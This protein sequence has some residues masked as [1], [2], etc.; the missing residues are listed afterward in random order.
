MSLGPGMRGRFSIRFRLTRACYQLIQPKWRS[1]L[2]KIVSQ[3][4]KRDSPVKWFRKS[5]IWIRD[6]FFHKISGRHR[7]ISRDNIM[8]NTTNR[9]NMY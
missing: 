5:W 7:N 6:I 8:E 2:D 9:Y 1:L 4:I 3:I